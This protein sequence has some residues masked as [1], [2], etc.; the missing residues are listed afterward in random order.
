V[1]EPPDYLARMSR[2]SHDVV[3]IMELGAQ[4]AAATTSSA[5]AVLVR[6]SGRVRLGALHDADTDRRD[7]VAA[8]L[9]SV[10][11]DG[12]DSPFSTALESGQNAKQ[13]RQVVHF[14]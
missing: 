6:Q 5:A 10:A 2:S 12:P 3:A 7:V 8:A 13:F 14:S 9:E 11:L 1:R 4:V